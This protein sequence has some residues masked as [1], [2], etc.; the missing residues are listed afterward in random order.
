MFIAAKNRSFILASC[1]FAVFFKALRLNTLLIL[2][3]L[4]IVLMQGLFARMTSIEDGVSSSLT[5]GSA[6]IF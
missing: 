1:A 5:L 6:P 2:Q 4:V 3:L